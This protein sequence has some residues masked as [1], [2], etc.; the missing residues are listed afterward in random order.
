MSGKD[1]D[2]FAMPETG[3]P[4]RKRSSSAVRNEDG[5]GS[6][7][8]V[9]K[10]LR[11]DETAKSS[12]LQDDQIDIDPHW[13]PFVQPERKASIP[14]QED[15]SSADAMDEGMDLDDQVSMN[16]FPDAWPGFGDPN[17]P[18]AWDIVCVVASSLLFSH[19]QTSSLNREF[20]LTP[21][22]QLFRRAIDDRQSQTRPRTSESFSPYRQ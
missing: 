12:D 4:S 19:L 7:S 1:L 10:K 2:P 16:A 8:P 22:H 20:K 5:T 15:D 9:H 21:F 11:T 13:N 3:A 14:N 17:Q 18:K 6:S